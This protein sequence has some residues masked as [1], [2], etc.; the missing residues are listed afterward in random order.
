VNIKKS[1][2]SRIRGWLPKKP[3]QPKTNHNPPK[4]GIKIGI[5]I[6]IMGFVGGSLGAFASSF[7]LFSEFGVYVSAVIIVI[8]I[9]IVAATIIIQTRQKEERQRS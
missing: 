5:I 1:L 2:E 6:F 4:I 3:H 9:T 7:G 8:G